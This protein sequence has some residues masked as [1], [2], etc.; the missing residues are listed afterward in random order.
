MAH[1]LAEAAAL[2]VLRSG[3]G[4]DAPA[5]VGGVAL[6]FGKTGTHGVIV[7]HDHLHAFMRNEPPPRSGDEAAKPESW[8]RELSS[9]L[10]YLN[11]PPSAVA[12]TPA[13]AVPCH[14]RTICPHCWGRE[15]AEH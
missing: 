8:S 6:P 14:T 11:C 7:G 1:M 9:S 5:S 12:V 4:G 13:G 2:G 15:V 3:M 10:L